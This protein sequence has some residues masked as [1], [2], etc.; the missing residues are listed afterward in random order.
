[1][2]VEEPQYPVLLRVAGARCLVVGTGAVAEHKAKGL[3]D[4]GA[5]VTVVA[6]EDYRGVAGYRLVLTAAG[7]EIN[8]RVF[9]DAETA[10]VWVNAADDPDNCTFTLPAV[11]RRGAITVAVGTGGQSPAMATWLRRRIEAELGPE[12][13]V[14]LRLLAE[15]RE[16]LRS[17][18]IPTE[19]LSW[20]EAL[21]SGI[22]DLVRTGRVAEARE[23]LEA[24]L[25]SSLD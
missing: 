16:A 4:A 14:L 15:Q 1:M 2:P 18:G 21:D 20:Q 12:Y 25:S 22:L 23:R 19:N 24:C 10:G 8:R 13:D 17:K 11:A 6:A 7:P 3:I 5:D 9:L